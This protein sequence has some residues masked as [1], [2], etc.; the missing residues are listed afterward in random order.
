[1][2]NYIR[3]DRFGMKSRIQS[4]IK[5]KDGI[6]GMVPNRSFGSKD[7]VYKAYLDT[8]NPR[9]NQD[10]QIALA[11]TTDKRFQAFLER[12]MDGRYK[13]TSLPTIAKACNIGLAEFNHWWNKEST[14]R[15]I[16]IAQQKSIA[17][18]SDMADDAMSIEVVCDRC[19]GM[20]FV[21]APE[22]LPK[23]TLGYRQMKA[24]NEIVWVRT[25]P[26]C[27]GGKVRR[28]G[29]SHARDRVLEISGLLKKGGGVS[30]NVNYGGASHG[31]AIAELDCMTIDVNAES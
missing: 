24:G 30:V 4:L 23:D 31:S 22:G 3:V 21:A 29:D 15:S 1:M 5:E 20:A 13:R 10:V 6:R 7:K 26:V 19:D 11:S 25:C 2:R 8:I 28:P 12:I 9:D 17:I 16:A 14:Q 18:T 27:K